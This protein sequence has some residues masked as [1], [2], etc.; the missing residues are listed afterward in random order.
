MAETGRPAFGVNGSYM[1]VFALRRF[2]DL[3]CRGAVSGLDLEQ[4]GRRR[5]CI[6]ARDLA[7]GAA[8]ATAAA[9]R[10]VVG[11]VDACCCRSSLHGEGLPLVVVRI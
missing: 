2:G 3:L 11:R 9:L 5:L 6:T 7:V 4:I 10:A 8:V 1:A